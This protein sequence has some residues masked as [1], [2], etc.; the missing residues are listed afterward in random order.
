MFSLKHFEHATYLF[1]KQCSKKDQTKIVQ[2]RNII[3]VYIPYRLY[4]ANVRVTIKQSR[5]GFVNFFILLTYYRIKVLTNKLG[6]ALIVFIKTNYYKLLP[7]VSLCI[8]A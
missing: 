7:C 3:I 6:S 1:L 5:L 8:M 2:K 4:T